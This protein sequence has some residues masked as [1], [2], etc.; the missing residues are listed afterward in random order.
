MLRGGDDDRG[1]RWGSCFE[2]GFEEG[3]KLRSPER[4]RGQSVGVGADVITVSVDAH[5]WLIA[6]ARASAEA[7]IAVIGRVEREN[8]KAVEGIGIERNSEKEMALGNTGREEISGHG[9]EVDFYDGNE[10][11]TRTG[12][13]KDSWVREK[14]SKGKNGSPWIGASDIC[15]RQVRGRDS[16]SN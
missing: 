12:I 5:Q 11:P 10:E 8:I 15:S 3:V 2:G 6:K 1:A 16:F 4:T 14:L 7:C 9:I 13:E